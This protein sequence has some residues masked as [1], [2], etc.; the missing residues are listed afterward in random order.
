[1]IAPAAALAAVAPVRRCEVDLRPDLR[2][3]RVAPGAMRL[4]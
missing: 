4:S 1:V 2:G 3:G